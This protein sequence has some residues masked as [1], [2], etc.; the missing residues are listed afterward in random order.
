MRTDTLYGIVAR[1]DDKQAVE[2]VYGVRHRESKKASI[3][4]I[5]NDRQIWNQSAVQVNKAVLDQFWPGPVSI[6]LPAGSESP[7]HIYR[8]ENSIAFRIPADEELRDLLSATGPL[9][10]PSANIEGE[11]PAK[12]IEEAYEYFGDYVEFY[13]DSGVCENTAPSKII[14]IQED[15]ELLQLR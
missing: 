11:P 8:G 14:K 3:V 7:S 10:A 15:G 4:L 13:V 9:I 6:I 1:A 2:R 5:A 12:T